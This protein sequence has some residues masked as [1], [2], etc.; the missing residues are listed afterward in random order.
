LTPS[1]GAARL[2]DVTGEIWPDANAFFSLKPRDA[3][4]RD[5]LFHG[6]VEGEALTAI[7]PA[8]HPAGCLYRVSL[9][10]G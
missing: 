1:G 3:D 10:R 2:S 7:D 4:G 5:G 8:E 6:R 9:H